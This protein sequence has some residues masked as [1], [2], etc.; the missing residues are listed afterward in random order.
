MTAGTSV[1][2]KACDSRRKWTSMTLMSASA[3]TMATEPPRDVERGGQRG[4]T[5]RRTGRRAGAPA[6]SGRRRRSR[7]GQPGSPSACESG[8]IGGFRQPEGPPAGLRASPPSDGRRFT[9]EAPPTIGTPRGWYPARLRIGL[10]RGTRRRRRPAARRGPRRGTSACP[11][12]G[13]RMAAP[14]TANPRCVSSCAQAS[15]SPAVSSRKPI[16]IP[17]RSGS[18]GA[19]EAEL[20]AAQLQVHAALVGRAA[21]EAEGGLVELGHAE[22]IGRCQGQLPDAP[23]LP[24]APA[25]VS[26]RH[27]GASSA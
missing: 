11:P 26:A 13:R 25:A 6:P 17:S 7:P 8:A 2:E 15:T 21:L 14:T 3:K 9:L 1:S 19:A 12:I 24:H 23:H 5:R 16:C 4:V 10:S 27:L 18:L 20:E 22:W